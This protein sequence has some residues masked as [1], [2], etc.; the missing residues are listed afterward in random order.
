MTS[1]VTKSKINNI[2]QCPY[3]LEE[4]K[5]G[6]IINNKFVINPKCWNF[7]ILTCGHVMCNDCYYEHADKINTCACC[8]EKT[9]V[10]QFKFN[11]TYNKYDKSWK[12]L[13]EWF[14]QFNIN[15]MKIK[16]MEWDVD[17]NTWTGYYAR[18]RDYSLNI[19]RKEQHKIRQKKLK[20]KKERDRYN[21]KL[22]KELK[23][24]VPNRVLGKGE[25]EKFI[26]KA[27]AT[28]E[29]NTGSYICDKCDKRIPFKHKRNHQPKCVK[30]C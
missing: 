5:I 24:I 4:K 19:V 13:A 11:Q 21:I 16:L 27:K 18:I 12:T 2:F 29:S 22:K 28:I 25:M 8:R 14:C 23:K 17:T 1:Y 9:D 3:C 6:S 15:L 7:Q 30:I 20:I 26:I 10:Y